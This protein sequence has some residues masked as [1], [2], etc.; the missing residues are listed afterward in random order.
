[1]RKLII[2]TIAVL[3]ASIC[4]C[5]CSEQPLN[6]YGIQNG[7]I[8]FVGLPMTYKLVNHHD[9]SYVDTISV[10]GFDSTEINFIHAA[11]LEVDEQ[12]NVWAIEA[13][14]KRGVD[15]HPLDTFLVD[16]TL[17]NGTLPYLEVM[18]L[19]DNSNVDEYVENAKQFLGEEYDIDFVQ[20]NGKHY[21]TE[22]IY[23]SFVTDSTHVFNLE[24]IDFGDSRGII[25]PYWKQ[26]YAILGKDIPQGEPGTLPVQMHRSDKL[27]SHP[28]IT[29]GK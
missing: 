12:G 5:G 11:I 2:T 16:F 25:P 13:T 28:E 1:M 14:K 20:D 17:R 21:C 23:D 27:V 8:V 26:V 6:K 3:T 15:R 4:M 22:L 24:P 10:E 18:R 9:T 7:D 29:F 19:K